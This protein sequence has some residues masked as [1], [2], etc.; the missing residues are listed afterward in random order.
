MAET[1]SSPRL[2]QPPFPASLGRDPVTGPVERQTEATG[3]LPVLAKEDFPGLRDFSF[4]S[5]LVFLFT[6]L[7]IW[8]RH[9]TRQTLVLLP[10]IKPTPPA[11]EVQSQPLN[12]QGSPSTAILKAMN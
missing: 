4:H 7:L 1:G 6:Y 5:D 2:A 12:S 9:T 10:A 3:P 11:M 8:P